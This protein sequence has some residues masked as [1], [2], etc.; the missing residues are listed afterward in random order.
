MGYFVVNRFESA[1]ATPPK[2]PKEN[3][4]KVLYAMAAGRERKNEVRSKKEVSHEKEKYSSYLPTGRT[5]AQTCGVASD[6]V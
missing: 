5:Q 2:I 6:N 3:G 4:H 1:T